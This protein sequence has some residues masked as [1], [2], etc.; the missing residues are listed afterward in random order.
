MYKFSQ[1]KSEARDFVFNKTAI[2]KGVRKELLHKE[3]KKMA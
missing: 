3:S 2:E 1:M